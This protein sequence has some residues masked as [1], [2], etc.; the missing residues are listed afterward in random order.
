MMRKRPPHF[1]YEGT[2][3]VIMKIPPS[4]LRE[5]IPSQTTSVLL[6]HAE[7]IV[8]EY[9]SPVE[10]LAPQILHLVEMVLL[11]PTLRGIDFLAHL[12]RRAQVIQ[13]PLFPDAGPMV[14]VVV[15][16][17]GIADLLQQPDWRWGREATLLLLQALEA[18]LVLVRI[19]RNR[20][21]EIHLPLQARTIDPVLLQARVKR[22]THRNQKTR[23][24][25]ARIALWLAA[26]DAPLTGNTDPLAPRSET[27]HQ[28]SAS[29]GVSPIV[30]IDALETLLEE[31]QVAPAVRRRLVIRLANT[32][33]APIAHQEDGVP[34]HDP[35]AFSPDD[36]T[37]SS[38]S[39]QVALVVSQSQESPA[40]S[41]SMVLPQEPTFHRTAVSPGSSSQDI[42]AACDPAA[43]SEAGAPA[44]AVEIWKRV[45][46]LEQQQAFDGPNRLQ[47]IAGWLG[48]HPNIV[49]AS[50]IN[51][52]LQQIYPDERYGFPQ[53]AH[54]WFVSTYQRYCVRRLRISAQI[55]S[56]VASPF[57]YTQIEQALKAHR[58]L[59]QHTL[60]PLDRPDA[61]CIVDIFP[62]L[63]DDRNGE[64]PQ[65]RSPRE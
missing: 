33:T 5:T 34:S 28:R 3:T 7:P 29:R 13:S 56:W 42:S 18:L 64:D 47:E 19:R 43:P 4:P 51:V 21:T 38:A 41:D 17:H 61:S 36:E 2:D 48:E 55:A 8:G 20:A 11:D 10:R 59:Q 15:C 44:E 24:L 1:C 27:G 54:A 62:S 30:V 14:A 25:F 49:R 35:S 39:H 57:T 23:R 16:P 46:S 50:M 12:C 6:P 58:D 9:F 63:Q 65:E 37:V 32:L 45:C 40:L 60:L 22:C 31:E 52:M 26:L 53:D